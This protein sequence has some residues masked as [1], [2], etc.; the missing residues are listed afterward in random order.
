MSEVRI[1][2]EGATLAFARLGGGATLLTLTGFDRGQF[3]DAPGLHLDAIRVGVEQ[4]RSTAGTQPAAVRV[5]ALGP[6]AMT[7]GN[8]TE[9]A[10]VDI[11]VADQTETILEVP[12][13]VDVRAGTRLVL[14]FMVP[15][16]LTE[17]LLY[18]GANQDGESAPTLW[19]ATACDTPE[20][21]AD[22]G[23]DWTSHFVLEARARRL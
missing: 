22:Y 13:S 1:E 23:C 4:A 6:G 21:V 8:L 3:G 15:A 20:P 16:T 2:R 17:Q 10:R 18:M 12:I 9:L 11:E 5:H 19:R 14:E 7:V